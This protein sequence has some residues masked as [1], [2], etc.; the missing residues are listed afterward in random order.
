MVLPASAIA[1]DK[2]RNL[3]YA[4]TP[5]SDGALSNS[6]VVVDPASFTV[7]STQYVGSDPQQIAV[8]D[9][10]SA[11]HVALSGSRSVVTLD[12]LTLAIT[13]TTPLVDSTS[14][15]QFPPFGIA[16]VPGSGSAFVTSR[17]L[18]PFSG[19]WSDPYP[20]VVAYDGGLPV[21]DAIYDG[22][23]KHSVISNCG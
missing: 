13:R 6:V 21:A 15:A 7:Q 11:V 10:S 3:I 23:T 22:G 9:S 18:G 1:Y 8:S 20:I 12:P 14:A 19:N 17:D 4:A 5:S 2:N 16:A